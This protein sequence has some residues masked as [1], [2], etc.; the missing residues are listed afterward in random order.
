MPRRSRP[1]SPFDNL[2]NGRRLTERLWGF[3]FRNEMYIP[4]AKRHYGYYLLPILHGDRLVGRAAPRFD[5]SRGVLLIEGLYLETDIKPTGALC[6]AVTGQLDDLAAL[7]GATGI[8]YGDTVPG[9][10]R[11]MLHRS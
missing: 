5:R 2:I 10:W 6:R 4:K 7:I 11:P 3:A 9:R 8:E 1:P